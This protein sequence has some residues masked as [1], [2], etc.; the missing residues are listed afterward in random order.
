MGKEPTRNRNSTKARTICFDRHAIC[1]NGRFFMT[2]HVCKQ[3][4]DCAISTWEAD[5]AVPHALGGQDTADNL[6]PAHWQCHRRD[7][8]P[9]DIKMISKGK[10]VRAKRLGIKRSKR[11][12][13]GSKRSGLRKRMN[14]M[15]ERR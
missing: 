5:H 3:E 11:P 7:K 10:R 2:C 13:P 12:M 6:L 4:F 8:T 1:R 15:V 9:G 14:G